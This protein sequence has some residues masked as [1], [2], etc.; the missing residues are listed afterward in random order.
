VSIRVR[1]KTQVQ[2]DFGKRVK[3]K[4]QALGFT[5]EQLAERVGLTYS[6]LGSIERG[7]RNVSLG[8]IV[9]LAQALNVPP[10]ELLPNPEQQEN[11]QAKIELGKKLK[12]KRLEQKMTPQELARKTNLPADDIELFEQGE[13]VIS[14]DILVALVLVPVNS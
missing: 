11:L 12:T 8:N 9:A 14:F 5:Q 10:K 1:K 3:I 13:G 7:E 6:Y 2:I 4:R